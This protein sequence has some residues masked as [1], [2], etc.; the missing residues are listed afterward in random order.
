MLV[1][2]KKKLKDG[3]WLIRCCRHLLCYIRYT[4]YRVAQKLTHFVF[5][6]QRQRERDDV[7]EYGVV[8]AAMVM[9]KGYQ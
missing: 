8:V 6:A 2:V 1:I 5:Y 4:V 7:C 3:G 9:E